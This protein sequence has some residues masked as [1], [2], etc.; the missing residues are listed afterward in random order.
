MH[1]PALCRSASPTIPRSACCPTIEALDLRRIDGR[2]Q[3]R[4]GECLLAAAPVAV[5]C[6]SSE[7][8]P[9]RRCRPPQAQA[10]PRADQP[11]AGHPASRA[12]KTVLCAE[13]YVRHRYA[14]AST[15]SAPAST[16]SA[17][18]WRCPPGAPRQPRHAQADLPR[19]ER[20]PARDR[21]DPA[22]S[23]PRRL[24]QHHRGLPAADRPAGR[25]RGAPPRRLRSP[26][27]GRQPPLRHPGALAGRP[28]RQR[29]TRL[30]RA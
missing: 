13:G 7:I 1:P 27:Q 9:L 11:P 24:P 5:L 10:H 3:A 16:S 2:W 14:A 26:G 30:T 20:G 25:R 12:L 28:V 4:Q 6:T 15:P 19:P 23:G 17:T 8:R 29:R 22:A 21:L 18:T